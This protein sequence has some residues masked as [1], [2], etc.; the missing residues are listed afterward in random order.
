MWQWGECRV[1][2]DELMHYGVKG[3]KHGVRRYQNEDGTLTAEGRER[4]GNMYDYGSSKTK[5]LIRRQAEKSYGMTRAFAEWREGRHQRN[6]DKINSKYGKKIEKQETAKKDLKKAAKDHPEAR[7]FL[8]GVAKD[9][10]G[11][12]NK[13]NDKKNKKLEKYQSK[14]DAQSAANKN[15]EAYRNHSSTGKLLLR[16]AAYEHARARGT[17]KLGSLMEASG[18][19]IG[20][21]LRMKRDKKAY[22]KRIVYDAFG[23]NDYTANG[24]DD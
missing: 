1:D 4:Y 15:L 21:G 22:G 13:L 23:N 17:S 7:D 5:G 3:Q 24:M 18:G 11:K 14:L 2:S 20:L 8:N 9:T 10:Q 16:S 6:I 19:L 12:I